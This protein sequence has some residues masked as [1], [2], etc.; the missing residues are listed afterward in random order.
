MV[1]TCGA[2]EW[3]VVDYESVRVVGWKVS[4]VRLVE[5]SDSKVTGMD[6]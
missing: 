2:Y 4:N 5:L 6:R 3:R 1:H